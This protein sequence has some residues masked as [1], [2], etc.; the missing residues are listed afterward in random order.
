MIWDKR[1]PLARSELERMRMHPYLGERMLAFSPVLA[2]IGAL[3][4]QH[5][6]RMDGS[7]Y[8]KGL[9]G[10]AIAP[11]ARLLAAA[12][13]YHAMTEVRPHR[14]AM[15]PEAAAAALSADAS[16]GRIDGAAAAAVLRASGHRG[17]KRQEW[18]AGLTPREVEVLRLLARGLTTK[19]IAASL[20]IA[21]KTAANH[22]E[23]IYVKINATN[24]AT[25]TLFAMK[26]H[27]MTTP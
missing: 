24:R 23:H 11:A 7:G 8:P 12:D 15:L 27:L 2:P 3:A 18:P 14:P 5:H 16:A 25:A 1:S 6:E 26:H 10:D 17:A 19:E 13:A 20:D 21:T 22:V 9:A 4:A